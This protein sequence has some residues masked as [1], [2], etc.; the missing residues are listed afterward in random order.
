M[1]TKELLAVDAGSTVIEV[2]YKGDIVKV[3]Y[4]GIGRQ[5]KEAFRKRWAALVGEIQKL[6]AK[7]L[8]PPDE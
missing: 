4:D 3:S 7:R 5:G 1:G 2:S 6:V 8:S